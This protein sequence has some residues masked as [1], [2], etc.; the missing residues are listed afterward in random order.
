MIPN[1][2]TS[3]K[4]KLFDQKQ[5]FYEVVVTLYLL[6]ITLLYLIELI[7]QKQYIK[8]YNLTLV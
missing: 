8:A 1:K 7:K 4:T 5:Y 2:T 3:Y 6:N